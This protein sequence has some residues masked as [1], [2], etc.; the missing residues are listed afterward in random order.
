MPVVI[1]CENFTREFLSVLNAEGSSLVR[2]NLITLNIDRETN[3]WQTVQLNYSM[4][5]AWSGFLGQLPITAGVFFSSWR[6]CRLGSA[7]LSIQV[8]NAEALINWE[9]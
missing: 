4:G 1:L 3:I 5:F 2:S 9:I 6:G 7:G 8:F